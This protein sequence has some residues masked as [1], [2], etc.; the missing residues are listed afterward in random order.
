[1]HR[2]VPGAFVRR[3]LLELEAARHRQGWEDGGGFS[4]NASLRVE[5]HDRAWLERLA[6]PKEQIALVYRLPKALP[7]GKTQLHLTPLE[8]LDRLAALDQSSAYDPSHGESELGFEFD[9]TIS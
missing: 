3:G 5:A 8:L 2:R 6:R 4:V 7:D 1:M 9:Q